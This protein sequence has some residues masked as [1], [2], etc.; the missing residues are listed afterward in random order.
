[1][2]VLYLIPGLGAGG[3]AERSLL[4]MTPHLDAAGVDLTVAYFVTRATD[5]AAAYRDAGAT[6]VHIEPTSWIGRVR[7][8][9]RL[10]RSVRPDLL[11]TT[12]YDADL[13]GRI[14]A[15]GSGVD[16]LTSFVSMNFDIGRSADPHYRWGRVELARFATSVTAR[17]LTV[18]AHAISDAARQSAARTLGFP[19]DE[20]TVIHRGRDLAAAQRPTDVERKAVRAEVGVA[21]DAPMILAV[22]RQEFQKDHA[23]LVRAM[24][25]VRRKHPGAVLAIAGRPGSMTP[26]IEALVA[27]LDLHDAV[28]LL[29]HR[30]DV[31]VL[32]GS[33][34][35]LAFSSVLEGFGAA[36]LEAVAAGVPMVVSRI[37]PMIEIFSGTDIPLATAGDPRS[38]ADAIVAGLDDPDSAAA[39]V[40]SARRHLEVAFSTE[41]SA[42]G[43]VELYRRLAGGGAAEGSR[44]SRHLVVVDDLTRPGGPIAADRQPAD[45]LLAMST[46]DDELVIAAFAAVP[47]ATEAAFTERGIVVHRLGGASKVGRAVAL[48]RLT[49]ALAPVTVERVDGRLGLL[50]RVAVARSRGGA[51]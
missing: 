50:E 49:S 47:P 11:H 18:A 9:R 24:P 1:V 45:R 46:P 41:R 21:E 38:F 16:V 10:L 31:D 30:D 39:V 32:L 43:L 15:I 19:I 7:A 14:A 5:N 33:A 20:V 51:R 44:R 13:I 12:L 48:R 2:K 17:H 25:L 36:A 42:A 29:G 27:E 8:V 35:M 28:R 23:T 34:D 4:G 26:R 37:P 6:V 22:G 3:G 40:E